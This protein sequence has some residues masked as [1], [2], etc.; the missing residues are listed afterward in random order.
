MHD[1]H[2]IDNSNIKK[3]LFWKDGLHSNCS[4]E[5]FANEQILARYQ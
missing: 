5:D 3:E 2:F 4:D 1:F